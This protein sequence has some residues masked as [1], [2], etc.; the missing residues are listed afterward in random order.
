[1]KIL[2]LGSGGREHALCWKIAQSPLVSE[3]LCAPGNGG[4]EEVARNVELDITDKGAVVSLARREGIALVVIG[5]EDALVAGVADALREAGVPAFGPGQAGAQLEGSKIYSKDFLERHRIP[6]GQARSFD[7]SGQAKGYLEGMG[8]WPLVIKAD[9]LAAGKG[10]YVVKDLEQGRAAIDAIMEERRHGRSGERILIEEFLV[11]EEASVFA[12]TDGST[13]AIL[14]IV[15]DHKQVGE[16]DTGPNTGGMGVYSPVPSLN[17]RMHK[18]IEQRILVPTVHALR[19]EGIAYQGVLFVGLMLTESGPRVIEYNV[20]F[21]D[22]ECQALMRRLKSDI[23]PVLLAAAKGDLE[24]IEPPEWDARAVVGVVAAAAGYPETPQ[25]GDVIE[26]LEAAGQVEEVIVF[27]AGT[28]AKGQ[29]VLT[30]GGRVLCVTAMA[31]DLEQARG[32][33]YEAYDRIHWDGK[34]CRR[35]IG[36][37]HQPPAT[38]AGAH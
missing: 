24:S 21:G 12:I 1:M 28:K 9:G 14:E 29:N 26:G 23:V 35:D 27:Q 10:V 13:I 19:K 20:R 11:G 34:F 36:T 37:R 32:R 7:R 38:S 17:A 4:T 30:N 18:Q 5:P 22:P 8:E 33:A 31:D 25:K 3:V 16:G 2:V 15:Q 6:T